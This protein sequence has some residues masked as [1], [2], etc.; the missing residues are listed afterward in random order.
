MALFLSTY[1]KKIDKK[2]RV[3]VPNPFRA[4]LAA[5]ASA[6]GVVVYPSFINPC[7]EACGMGRIEALAGRIEALDPFSEEY[8]VFSSAILGGSQELSFDG[9]GRIMLPESLLKEAS[10]G[11]DV[12]FVGKGRTFEI[13]EPSRHE[14]H[15]R[16]AR[17]LALEKRLLLRAG[18]GEG[19]V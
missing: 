18:G 2:G 1:V 11:G 4:V 16:E 5:E 12:V 13:W 6:S 7:I 3:L 9:E 19:G 15:A 17:K 14:T 8:D 10:I